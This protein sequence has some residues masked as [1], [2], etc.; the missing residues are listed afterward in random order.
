VKLKRVDGPCPLSQSV[1]WRWQRRFYEEQGP[2]AFTSGVVPWRIT[3]CLLLASAY[4]DAAIAFSRDVPGPIQVLELGGGVGRLAFNLMR[5]LKDRGAPFHY[6]SPDASQ[7]NLDA[8]ARHP[9]LREWIKPGQLSLQRLDALAPG[10]LEL[11]AG[12]VVVV[13]N[14]L[15]DS[16]PHDAWRS[17]DGIAAA[18]HVEVWSP[19][20]EAPL[21]KIEWKFVDGATAPSAAVAGYAAGFSSGRF[22]WPAGSIACIQAI[23]ARLRRPHL[24]LAADKGPAVRAQIE[25]Q[26]TATLARHGCVSA[27]VNFDALRAW[28]GW[29]PFLAPAV[30]EM[31]FGAYALV[32]GVPSGAVPS[33]RAAWGEAAAHNLPLQAEVLLEQL[34]ASDATVPHLL[35]ALAFTRFDPDALLRVSGLLRDRLSAAMSS[36]EVAALVAALDETWSNRFDLAEPHDLAFEIATVLHRAGQLSNAATYYRRSIELRGAHAT[37]F[38][39]LALCLLDLGKLAEARTALEGTLAADATHPRARALLAATG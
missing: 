13:A 34:A 8:A 2:A 17:E 32:Q 36:A 11:P 7:A 10:A 37:T 5:A 33:L 18:E 23:S 28:A 24:W 6:R 27:S 16:L 35:Q 1:L 20:A 29:R 3:S 21:E 4:A 9:Q 12:P 14:Y 30:P 22:L 15:F 38:F 26:D 19:G 39:N 25:G 31:R